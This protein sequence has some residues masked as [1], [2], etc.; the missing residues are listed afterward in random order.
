MKHLTSNALWKYLMKLMDELRNSTM[1]SWFAFLSEKSQFGI[2]AG[3]DLNI[4]NSLSQRCAI[5]FNN[6]KLY[7]TYL[8]YLSVSFWLVVKRLSQKINHQGSG[9]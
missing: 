6:V 1:Q 7:V 2:N 8:L 4:F 5:Y 3:N 9:L